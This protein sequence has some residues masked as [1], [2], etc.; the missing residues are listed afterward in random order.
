MN[1]LLLKLE[2][3]TIEFIIV[4]N[5]M[6]RITQCKGL[7]T[8]AYNTGNYKTFEDF[9]PLIY[10]Y[11][12]TG[13]EYTCG[14]KDHIEKLLLTPPKKVIKKKK[15]HKEWYVYFYFTN[16]IL[17]VYI[18]KTYDVH[19]R[20]KQHIKENEKYKEVKSIL[21]ITFSSETD[22]LDYERYYTEH[23]QPK[24]NISNKGEPP[25]YKLPKQLVKAWVPIAHSLEESNQ[26]LKQYNISKQ[27]AFN[28]QKLINEISL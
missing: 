4:V 8:K 5:K 3:F 2:L 28:F 9:I 11:K 15:E 27:R 12:I 26:L 21:T 10:K 25:S 16:G 13:F 24:W 7:L 14:I 20:L 23:F 6:D 17:P 19:N 1:L 22:A 18:G